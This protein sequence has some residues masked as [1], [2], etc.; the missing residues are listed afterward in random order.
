MVF[1]G[2]SVRDC[3]AAP[4]AG[5]WMSNLF[6]MA[7]GRSRPF[8]SVCLSLEPYKVHLGAKS[9]SH[10]RDARE[11]FVLFVTETAGV[12]AYLYGHLAGDKEVGGG[13]Q[14]ATV[15]TVVLTMP[16]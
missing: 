6:A 4:P 13:Q 14:W 8:A 1:R 2:N 3:F 11:H 7:Q 16:V 15:V 5:E 9:G 10:V 12:S